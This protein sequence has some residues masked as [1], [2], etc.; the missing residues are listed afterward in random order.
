MRA[1][2]GRRWPPASPR[3]ARRMCCASSWPIAMAGCRP[4]SRPAG[5]KSIT[6]LE[7]ERAVGEGKEVLAFL[8]DEA[9]AWPAEYREEEAIA[10]AVREGRASPELLAEVQAKVRGL[11]DLKKWLNGRAI[12]ARFTTPED[13]RGKLVAA[14]YDWRGRHPEYAA[15]GHRDRD[16]DPRRSDALSRC[17]ALAHRLHRH[18]RT[19]G[20]HRQ[21]APLPHRGAV[22]PLEHGR[23][24]G[25]R[26]QAWP[27]GPGQAVP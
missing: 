9:V 23:R 18:P 25:T 21:G 15:P 3:S 5:I 6:W 13:L 4:T 22:H 1:G 7:C 24:S 14:L 11:Q 27:R 8:L 26:V 12:T 20:R 10:R 2:I 16:S 17:A 19:T